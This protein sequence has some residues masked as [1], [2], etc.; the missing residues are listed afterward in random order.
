MRYYRR[1]NR[2]MNIISLKN[3]S[4]HTHGEQVLKDISFSL[5]RGDFLS[6]VGPNGSGKTTL[7]QL[8][9]GIKKQTK[10]K[11]EYHG[12]YNIGYVPQTKTLDRTFPAKAIELVINGI[13]KKWSFFQNKEAK[14][15]A[16]EV[17]DLLNAKHL[18]N[19]QLSE[20]SGGELQR[21]YLARAIISQPELLLLDE[22]STGIDLVCERD[23]SGIITEL[24]TT[25]HTTIIMVTH[26][27]TSA[28]SHS[29]KV[30]LLNE[31]VIYF[32]DV[33][34]G[35]TDENMLKT[36]TGLQ[37][38]HNITFGITNDY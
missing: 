20:L 23:I 14:N 10:G 19:R 7:L 8:M 30:L 32:G 29:N 18:T 16:T 4:Y 31:E 9:L 22:P 17:L 38:H 3:I 26:D 36:F 13:T 21:I 5:E 2:N 12:K 1:N 25:K 34:Q 33:K 37:H 27:W 15:K 35:F 24:N 6:I 28:Y 11:I